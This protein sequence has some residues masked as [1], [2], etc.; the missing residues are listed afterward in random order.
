MICYFVSELALEN[1]INNSKGIG[2]AVDCAH[3]L[4]DGVDNL[5]V[6]CEV[7][8]VRRRSTEC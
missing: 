3:N 7:I 1:A 6:L 4:L 5:N 2:V 8:N